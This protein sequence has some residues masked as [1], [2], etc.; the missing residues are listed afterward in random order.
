MTF[1]P[2]CRKKID[3]KIHAFS[4]PL[5]PEKTVFLFCATLRRR[6]REEEE[7]RSIEIF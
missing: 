4:Q 2:K 6:R 5:W 7:E 1:T 3:L